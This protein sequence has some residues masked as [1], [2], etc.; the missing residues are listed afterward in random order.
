MSFQSKNSVKASQ[1]P[2]NTNIVKNEEKKTPVEDSSGSSGG[3][4]SMSVRSVHQSEK[5]KE[6]IPI[7]EEESK[8]ESRE[9]RFQEAYEN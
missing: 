7:Q 6:R 1:Q 4:N 8:E 2:E 3:P 9:E 5:S